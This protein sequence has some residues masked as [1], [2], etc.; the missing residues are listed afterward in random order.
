MPKWTFYLTGLGLFLGAASAPADS[1]DARSI[2]PARSGVMMA[3]AMLP[4]G[5]PLPGVHHTLLEDGMRPLLPL[6]A[7][8]APAGGDTEADD[9]PALG[10]HVQGFE[11]VPPAVPR[12]YLAQGNVEVS[13]P[14]GRALDLRTGV[15]VKYETGVSRDA[16]DL[17]GTPTLGFGLRF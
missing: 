2:D 4:M 15:R 10:L 8:I 1:P 7:K 11:L 3:A 17:D 12:G 16:L 5:A 6:P 14:L 13:L 9:A